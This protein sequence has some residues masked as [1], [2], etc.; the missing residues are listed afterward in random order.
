MDYV[1]MANIHTTLAIPQLSLS[2]SYLPQIG[3]WLI[4]VY[5]L[6]NYG[7]TFQETRVGIVDK[8]KYIIVIAKYASPPTDG[9][10]LIFN[11][12][13]SFDGI[14]TN[15]Q[16]G[17]VPNQYFKVHGAPIQCDLQGNDG[18]SSNRCNG[19]RKSV[20]DSA[21]VGVWTIDSAS[22]SSPT[23]KPN[24]TPLTTPWGASKEG[25]DAYDS[26]EEV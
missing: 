8:T 26:A 7:L 12:D 17:S 10:A 16:Y 23:Q 13:A 19:T 1:D 4:A 22:A 25:R 21:Q 11:Q 15:K 20:N 18:N 3:G 14:M 9:T 6:P 5:Y 24:P 2:D